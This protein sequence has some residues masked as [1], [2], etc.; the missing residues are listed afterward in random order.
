MLEARDVTVV[1]GG[2]PVLDGAALRLQPGCVTALVGPNGAGKSTL[3]ACLSGAL[4]PRA[5]SIL[6]DGTDPTSLSPAA[7]CLQRAVLDQTPAA[8]APFTLAELVELGIP[9]AVS[10]ADATRIVREAA[11]SLGLAG[12]LDRGIDALSGG[13]RHR[14]HMARALAQ[15]R[16]G[17]LLGGGRWLL[18]DEPTASLDLRHQASVMRAARRAAEDGVG[19]LAVLHDLSLA[20]AMADTVALMN[21]GRIVAVGTPEETLTNARLAPV[22]GLP[23]AISEPAPGLRAIVPIYASA[24]GESQCS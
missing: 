20:G 8:A 23:V 1:L 15:L 6:M 13:E 10:P 3:L 2:R 12:L 4:T 17:Q 24:E 11:R 14:A 5:G 16:A 22:Y 9:R 21:E 19:V 18:L 7:L